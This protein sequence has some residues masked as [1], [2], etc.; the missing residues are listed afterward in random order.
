M[1]YRVF[2]YSFIFLSFHTAGAEYQS[3]DD[4]RYVV[5]DSLSGYQFEVREKIESDFPGCTAYS[6]HQ[7][8]ERAL[9]SIKDSWTRS[10]A[11]SLKPDKGCLGE[12]GQDDF[13]LQVAQWREGDNKN[14]KHNVLLMLDRLKFLLSH[15]NYPYYQKHTDGRSFFSI[16]FQFE[17][18]YVDTSGGSLQYY[19]RFSNVSFELLPVYPYGTGTWQKESSTAP[20]VSFQQPLRHI[21]LH[22]HSVL[23]GK[24]VLSEKRVSPEPYIVNGSNYYFYKASTKKTFKSACEKSVHFYQYSKQK[25]KP[26]FS[27]GALLI[28]FITASFGLSFYNPPLHQYY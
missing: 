18:F 19:S 4:Q 16:L 26:V 15:Q 23:L 3:S 2:I 10:L 27:G 5:S 1:F 13:F 7:I 20:A 6:I 25:K 14:D 17:S 24:G 21:L 12:R 8:P 9:R 28:I 22:Q 11:C